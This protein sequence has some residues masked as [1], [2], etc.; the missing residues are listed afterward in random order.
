MLVVIIGAIGLG[1]NIISIIFLHEHD[2]GHGHSHG[3]G[4]DH[5]HAQPGQIP[6][7]VPSPPPEIALATLDVASDTQSADNAPFSSADHQEHRHTHK[8]FSSPK[9]HHDFGMMGV[10]L[11]VLGDAVNNIGV[12]ISGL[13]IWKTS[14]PHRYYADPAVGM[15]IALMILLTSLPLVKKTGHI[16]LQSPPLG[17]DVN[18]IKHDLETIPSVLSVHELHV[19]RLNQTK[20][21]ASAHV[22]VGADTSVEEFQ[23]VAKTINECLHAYGVHSVTLQPEVQLRRRPIA[24]MSSF[25]RGPS[26]DGVMSFVTGAD[27]TRTATPLVRDDDDISPVVDELPASE[28]AAAGGDFEESDAKKQCLMNCGMGCEKMTCCG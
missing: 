5:E 12:I 6:L 23:S 2:H 19:W 24:G 17:I 3:H 7:Q 11:H 14:S 21:L 27:I 13:I 10:L 22:V 20:S 15:A 16:L 9:H 4:H 8:I 1:L 25:S 28:N 26:E 18:D